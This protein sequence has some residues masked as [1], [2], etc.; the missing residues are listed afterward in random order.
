MFRLIKQSEKNNARICEFDTPHG[1]IYTPKFMPIATYGAVKTLDIND[2][3]KISFEI[4]LSNTYHLYLRPGIKI[5]NKVNGLHRFMNWPKAILT[6]SGGYQVFSL[7]KF[8]EINENGIG[9]YS[10]LDGSYH[11]LS[12]EKSI[13]IQLY[14]G[15]D[16]IMVL[17]ECPPFTS[18]KEYLKNSVNMTTRWAQR[19]KIFFEQNNEKLR[20]NSLSKPL[21]FGIIQ[22]GSHFDLRKKSLKQLEDIGFD[23]Y[24]IG[25]LS[26]GEGTEKMLKVVNEIAHLLPKQSPRYLMGVG[27]PH[28]IVECVKLGIDMFDCV[29]PSRHARHG[30]LFVFNNRNISLKNK[31]RNSLDKFFYSIINISNEK[32]KKD[33]SGIDS[34]CDCF[35]CRN[36]TKAYLRHLFKTNEMLGLR[37]ATIHNLYFYNELMNILKQKIKNAD[38]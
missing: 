32:Y 15:S 9:F 28:E 8:R 37:L 38:I 22:G 5:I 14:L 36:Y 10:H 17:D 35:T 18:S 33:F 20:Y 12:P 2:L 11:F 21:I 7:A 1:K 30:S 19:C 16:I 3:N 23:G 31:Q 13:E 34:N 24:A 25:G 29:I 26:V 6:D 27:F 4:I